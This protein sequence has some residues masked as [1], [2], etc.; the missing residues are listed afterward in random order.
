MFSGSLVCGLCGNSMVI[1]AGGGK[2]G[3]VKYG[4]HSYKHNG[5]CPNRMMIRQERLESQLL[6]AIGDRILNPTMLDYT[7]ERCS[8]ELKRRIAEMKANGSIPSVESLRKDLEDRKRRQTNLI[9]AIETGVI[10]RV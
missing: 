5:V 8:Q 4:C 9:N 1:C 7:V 3:Y 2:R 6:G 10:S